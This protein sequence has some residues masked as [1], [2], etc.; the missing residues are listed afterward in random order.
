MKKLGKIVIFISLSI[1][2]LPIAI[3]LLSVPISKI[4]VVG[5]VLK[6][7]LNVMFGL[8]WISVGGM[9]VAVPLFIVGS[10]MY[11]IGFFL[12]RREEKINNVANKNP[13][14]L[15]IIIGIGLIFFIWYGYKVL[16]LAQPWNS[17]EPGVYWTLTHE[18]VKVSP[19][20]FDVK[21]TY[22][23]ARKCKTGDTPTGKFTIDF[24]DG[25][26]AQVGCKGTI[27]HI[28]K[29]QEFYSVAYKENDLGMIY[30]SFKLGPNGEEK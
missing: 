12:S 8:H 5:E 27:N 17:P 23:A 26:V 21:F 10:L 15:F 11:L 14:A 9:L 29:N 6:P 20:G 16:S 19:E 3:S 18:V 25:T 30:T 7:L 28:Y 22:Q 4:P 13:I 2:I 1:S 24:K